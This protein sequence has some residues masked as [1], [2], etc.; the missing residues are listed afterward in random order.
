MTEDERK[1]KVKQIETYETLSESEKKKEEL[2]FVGALLTLSIGVN[3]IAAAYGGSYT[4]PPLVMFGSAN[5][6]VTV[7]AIK[8]MINAISQKTILKEQ[9][10]DLYHELAIDEKEKEEKTRGGK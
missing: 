10:D 8:Y 5:L 3:A 7:T 1:Y 4:S 9:I 6:G 2:L